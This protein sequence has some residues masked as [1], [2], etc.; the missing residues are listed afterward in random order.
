MITGGRGGGQEG[1]KRDYVIF[2]CSLIDKQVGGAGFGGPF[3]ICL[4]NLTLN[5]KFK[6]AKMAPKYVQVIYLGVISLDTKFQ[7]CSSSNS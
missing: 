4:L 2:E 3:L 6:K 5:K 7:L 1:P